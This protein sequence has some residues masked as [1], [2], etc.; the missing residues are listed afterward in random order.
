MG[1]GNLLYAH[2]IFGLEEYFKLI[3]IVMNLM[4]KADIVENFSVMIS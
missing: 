1:R 3:F 4:Y 2:D